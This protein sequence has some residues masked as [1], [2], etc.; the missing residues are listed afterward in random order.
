MNVKNERCA[1]RQKH[2]EMAEEKKREWREKKDKGS[3]FVYCSFFNG[4]V[5]VRCEQ[6]AFH[7]NLHQEDVDTGEYYCEV[8]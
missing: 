2:I 5:N 8:L 7:V 6:N 4:I 3:G 1:G